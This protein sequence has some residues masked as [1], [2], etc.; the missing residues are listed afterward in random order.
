MYTSSSGR[1]RVIRRTSSSAVV[2]SSRA[3]VSAFP[4]WLL[5][6][7]SVYSVSS[8]SLDQLERLLGCGD[9]RE[10]DA[11]RVV[12]AARRRVQ[13]L[14]EL[15]QDEVLVVDHQDAADRLQARL[16]L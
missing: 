6:G 15:A 11:E 12:E 14:H 8:T 16:S 7:A 9:P 5:R 13:A 10:G 4:F 2:C 1:S 3:G